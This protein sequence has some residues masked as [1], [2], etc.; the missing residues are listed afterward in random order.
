MSRTHRE[1]LRITRPLTSLTSPTP[2]AH[3]PR[4]GRVSIWFGAILCGVS[5]GSALLMI[6][7]DKVAETKLKRLNTEHTDAEEEVEKEQV[8]Q[9]RHHFG[10]ISHAFP[11]YTHHPHA[12][13]SVLLR[14]QAYRVL[15]GAW[16]PML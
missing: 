9:L 5:M 6:F 8:R 2:L 7:M 1:G 14:A 16:N 10:P 3:R 13:R 4:H 12:V 11:S 15:I